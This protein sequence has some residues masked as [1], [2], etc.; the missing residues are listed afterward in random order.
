[1]AQLNPPDA[2]SAV[3]RFLEHVG[4]VD[5]ELNV[6]SSLAPEKTIRRQALDSMEQR[7]AAA[8]KERTSQ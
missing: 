2:V 4:P 5:N 7:P 1:M 6:F 8:K 3:S